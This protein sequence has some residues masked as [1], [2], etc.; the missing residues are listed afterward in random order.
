MHV[1]AGSLLTGTNVLVPMLLSPTVVVGFFS[2]FAGLL[3]FFVIKITRRIKVSS[4]VLNISIST[5]AKKKTARTQ[6]Y[7]ALEGMIAQTKEKKVESSL[8]LFCSH[9]KRKKRERE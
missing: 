8:K 1:S 7:L 9:C 5:P 3:A 2:S 6:N 4:I